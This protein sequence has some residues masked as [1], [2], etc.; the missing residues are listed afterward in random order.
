MK[1]VQNQVELRF[2]ELGILEITSDAEDDDE[3]AAISNS[4]PFPLDSKESWNIENR[5][6]RFGGGMATLA[7]SS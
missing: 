3:D 1:I 7:T 5:R 2:K 6:S 4:V